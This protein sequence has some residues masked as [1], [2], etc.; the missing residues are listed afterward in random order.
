MSPEVEKIIADVAAMVPAL[1]QRVGKWAVVDSYEDP[2]L[3]TTRATRLRK[4]FAAKETIEGRLRFRA[5]KMLEGGAKVYVQL[6]PA[7]GDDES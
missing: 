5:A 7:E 3:A 2:K 6:R 1:R 4:H